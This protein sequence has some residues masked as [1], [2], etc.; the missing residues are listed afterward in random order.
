MG[1]FYTPVP[2]GQLSNNPSLDSTSALQGMPIPPASEFPFTDRL[3][4]HFLN[5][6]LYS[7]HPPPTAYDRYSRRIPSSIS[8]PT[9]GRDSCSKTGTRA[10][11]DSARW[12]NDQRGRDRPGKN[13]MS[14]SNK[15]NLSGCHL[16]GSG[17]QN[18]VWG[19]ERSLA[20]NAIS[21]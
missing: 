15:T 6:S 10:L 16:R 3:L 1:A 18:S 11:W 14:E 2:G 17:A 8:P 7:F 19:R 13:C 9:Q 20:G 4:V 5:S 12:R 21:P